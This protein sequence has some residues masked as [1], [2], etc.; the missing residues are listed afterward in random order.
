MKSFMFAVSRQM[1]EFTSCPFVLQLKL[2]Q[3]VSNSYKTIP[4]I[5]TVYFKYL[6][7]GIFL[8]STMILM[9]DTEL[10]PPPH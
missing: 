1:N 5:Y 7:N 9:S 2:Q 10:T 4:Y 6:F 3:V 8:L